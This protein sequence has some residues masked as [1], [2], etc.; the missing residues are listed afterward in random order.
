MILRR[1]LPAWTGLFAP[2]PARRRRMSAFA[3]MTGAL[4][5]GLTATA[6]AEP[7][8]CKREISRADARFSRAKIKILQHCWDNV[9]AGKKDGPCPDQKSN[10]RIAIQRAKL[11][12]SIARRCGG[13]DGTCSVTADNDPLPAIG[14][15]IGQCPNFERGSCTNSIN[16]CQHI[17]SCLLCIND[18]ALDQAIDLYYGSRVPT[19]DRE[20]RKCQ[21]SIGKEAS[22]FYQAKGKA[23][24]KCEDLVLKGAIP[25]PCPNE[26]ASVS[27]AKAEAK[28]LTKLCF[29]CG[30]PDRL[31]D[32]PD[33]PLPSDI[34]FKPDC[35]PVDPPGAEPSCGGPID[36]VSDLVSCVACV[37]GFKAD[38]VSAAGAPAVESYPPECN[39]ALPTATPTPTPTA[40]VS[41]T[42]TVSSTPTPMPT[43]TATATATPQVTA[44]PTPTATATE[45]P[46]ATATATETPQ[47]TS[48]PTAT[49]EPSDTPTP[50]E[51]PTPT[52]TATPE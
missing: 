52:E 22:K 11:Q 51:E 49:D 31:C 50:T 29:S 38:C 2:S 47:P 39:V 44:T 14:W 9:V 8:S 19:E 36:T 16:H 23:L 7:E 33:D 42:P 24:G 12:N 40:T 26:R 5:L 35:P 41:P 30:G 43:E 18:K 28:L 6:G 48:T 17:S 10:D 34:G 4:V 3:L 20:I 37:T 25:G 46:D 1:S 21:R 45:T 13:I 27:I 15:N 32:T